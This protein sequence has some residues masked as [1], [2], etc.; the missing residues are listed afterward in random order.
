MSNSATE[1]ATFALALILYWHVVLIVGGALSLDCRVHQQRHCLTIQG[2]ACQTRA[3]SS[4]QYANSM[5]DEA[6]P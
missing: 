6:C 3:L 1:T 2:F 4:I 5:P